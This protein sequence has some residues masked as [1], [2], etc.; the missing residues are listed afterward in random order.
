MGRLS[1]AK[2]FGH[3]LPLTK[4]NYL[5][6]TIIAAGLMTACGAGD[7]GSTATTAVPSSTSARASLA[8]RP[9][10]ATTPATLSLPPL[11]ADQPYIDN[12]AYDTTAGGSLPSATEGAAVTHHRITL[13]GQTLTYTATAGHLTV[14]D[15]ST[16]APTAPIFY[17]AYTLD[18]ADVTQRPITFFFNGGPG[19]SSNYLRMGSYGPLRVF[20]NRV[21]R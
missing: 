12:A 9:T 10:S 20:P 3:R 18:G 1:F 11:A 2:H 16:N 13:N 21:P 8:I 7:D 6:A 5:V 4:A 15:A 19:P 14:R 17:T